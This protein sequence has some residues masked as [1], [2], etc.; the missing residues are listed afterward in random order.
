MPRKTA[1]GDE[2][3]IQAF[4]GLAEVNL[5]RCERRRWLVIA[6]GQQLQPIAVTPNTQLLLKGAVVGGQIVVADRPTLGKLPFGEAQGDAAPAQALA[7]HLAA[8]GPEEGLL[9][10][11]CVGIQLL[12]DIEI[13]VVFP[14]ARV[15]T[16]QAMASS[17]QM[18]EAA[19]DV[20]RF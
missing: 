8:P 4:A 1:G 16:L 9:S 6:I 10:R 14:I 7:P 20:A 2:G 19:S 18:L 13:R 5:A 17:Q 15:L 11:G 12:I 3:Q